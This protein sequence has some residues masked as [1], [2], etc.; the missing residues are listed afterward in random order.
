MSTVGSPDAPLGHPVVSRVNP[1]A[2]ASTKER[3][4]TAA[5][6]P[7]K[8]LKLAQVRAAKR[9]WLNAG[10]LRNFACLMGVLLNFCGGSLSNFVGC[11]AV[12]NFGAKFFYPTLVNISGTIS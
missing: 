6:K 5:V 12:I 2:A 1:L 11:T 4:R 10:V 7:D 8:P 9:V 3:A